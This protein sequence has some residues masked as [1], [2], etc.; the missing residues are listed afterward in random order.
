MSE[1]YYCKSPR[2]Y[3]FKLSMTVNVTN[4]GI[5]I[6]LVKSNRQTYL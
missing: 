5:N 4:G 3:S 6:S 1:L 2:N